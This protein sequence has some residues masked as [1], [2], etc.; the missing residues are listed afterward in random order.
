MDV[1]DFDLRFYG[2]TKLSQY[3]KKNQ[4]SQSREIR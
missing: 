2:I 1:I 4:I 3:E